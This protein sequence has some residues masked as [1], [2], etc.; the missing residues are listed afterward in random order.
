[1]MNMKKRSS[2]LH[3]SSQDC[4]KDHNQ[5]FTIAMVIDGCDF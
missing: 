5:A 2:V 1:M 4:N 3:N